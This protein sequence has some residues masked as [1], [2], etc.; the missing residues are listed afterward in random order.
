MKSLILAILLVV[1]GN[2]VAAVND[3]SPAGVNLTKTAINSPEQPFMNLMKMSGDGNGNAWFTANSTGSDTAEEAYMPLDAYGY[4]TSMLASGLPSG[5]TQKYTQ[6]CTKM[7]W[8]IQ[9]A[10]G[11]TPYRA[12]NYQVSYTGS[13]TLTITGDASSVTKVS[14][15]QYTFTVTTPSAGIELCITATKTNSSNGNTYMQAM[16]VINAADAAAYS[17]GQIFDGRFLASLAPFHTIRASN[18]NNL[19]VL[20]NSSGY[21]LSTWGARADQNYVT[22][23]AAAGVPQEIIQNLCNTLNADCWVSLPLPAA[24]VAFYDEGFFSSWLANLKPNLNLYIEYGNDIWTQSNGEYQWIVQN[25]ALN[26]LSNTTGITNDMI[27]SNSVGYLTGDACDA[28]HA[29]WGSSAYR[30][31]CVVAGPTG[32]N[33][34]PTIT[35]IMTCPQVVANGALTTCGNHGIT[36]VAVAPFLGFPGPTASDITIM[37]SQSDGG[38]SQLFQSIYP[39]GSLPSKT[40]GATGF[41]GQFTTT[42]AGLSSYVLSYNTAKPAYPIELISWA[43]GPALTAGGVANPGWVTLYSAANRDF[44][45]STI[46]R[47]MMCNWQQQ[48]GHLMVQSNLVTPYDLNGSFGLI[49]NIMQM[50][51]KY[52]P[53]PPKYNSTTSFIQNNPCWWFGCNH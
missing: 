8:G 36:E 11:L 15:G 4:P 3:R 46:N 13:G 34:L 48:G 10:P 7:V 1:T 28:G 23:A 14:E 43:A 50:P 24:A 52:T 37:E 40:D 38:L 49:E 30:L 47:Q 41:M 12:G 26:F 25:P 6:Y 29:A 51:N 27:V 19:Q 21:A 16:S 20:P 53:G 42:V 5:V 33:P 35:A 31:K 32:L 2:A 45:M 22:Y 18:W 39:G 44:R 17:A 9:A